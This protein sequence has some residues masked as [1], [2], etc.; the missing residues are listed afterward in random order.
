MIG[1]YRK[2][3]I[4]EGVILWEMKGGRFIKQINLNSEEGKKIL[5]EHDYQQVNDV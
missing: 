4:Y 5:Q 3:G 2:D 1:C